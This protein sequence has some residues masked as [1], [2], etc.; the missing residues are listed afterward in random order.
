VRRDDLVKAL[1][2]LPETANL[3]L[4]VADLRE[5][6][7]DGTPVPD[8]PTTPRTEPDRLLSVDEACTILGMSKRWLYDHAGELPFTRRIGKFLRFS[9]RGLRQWV[10]RRR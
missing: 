8:S 9:E 5:A 3:T 7:D 6:M 4:T 2:A 1:A 10:E